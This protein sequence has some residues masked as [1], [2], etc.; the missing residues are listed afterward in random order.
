MQGSHIQALTNLATATAVDRQ[1]V[2]T[3]TSKK[4]ELT[5]E[6]STSTAT[7]TTLQR[8]LAALLTGH[9]APK[10]ARQANI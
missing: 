10:P 5:V 2:T 9:L 7:I 4:I 8:Q 1:M 3:L 6:I